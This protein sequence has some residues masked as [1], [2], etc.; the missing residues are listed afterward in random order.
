MD[1]TTRKERLGDFYEK[2]YRVAPAIRKVV[3]TG[4]AIAVT[5]FFMTLAVENF[6]DYSIKAQTLNNLVR[7]HNVDGFTPVR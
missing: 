6:V 4:L 5:F 2:H 7:Y 1:F 3:Y